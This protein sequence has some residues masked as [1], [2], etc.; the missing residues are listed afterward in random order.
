MYRWEKKRLFYAGGI[1]GE[2]QIRKDD[3]SLPRV[4]RNTYMP[5]GGP[6]LYSNWLATHLSV[7]WTSVHSA[8]PIVRISPH[9][10]HQRVLNIQACRTWLSLPALALAVLDFLVDTMLKPV[11][12]GE[13]RD[14]ETKFGINIARLRYRKE[15]VVNKK[16]PER[17]WSL[18][19]T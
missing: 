11:L 18:S 5:I 2:R 15:I 8:D 12:G 19:Q 1:H 7:M 6:M 17:R 14:R 9:G 4:P 13:R 16:K 3:G 10:N